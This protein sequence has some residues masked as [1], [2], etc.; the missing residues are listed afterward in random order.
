MQKERE[1]AVTVTVA[2][3]WHGP[4]PRVSREASFGKKLRARLLGASRAYIDYSNDFLKPTEIFLAYCG[5]CHIYYYDYKHGDDEH[6]ICPM[7]AKA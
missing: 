5:S 7:C 2:H 1:K 6:T 4:Y 3:Q